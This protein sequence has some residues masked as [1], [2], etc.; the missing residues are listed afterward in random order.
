MKV[1]NEEDRHGPGFDNN[2]PQGE[3]A[4]KCDVSQKVN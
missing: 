2:N 3:R 4:R 1:L